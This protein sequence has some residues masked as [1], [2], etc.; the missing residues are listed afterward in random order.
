MT[1]HVTFG[2]SAGGSLRTALRTLGRGD[3]VLYLADDL[4]F[5]PIDVPNARHRMQW[6]D[7]ELGL[8]PL[9]EIE[10]HIAAFWRRVATEET[11]LVAW[12]SR[13]SVQEYCGFLELLRCAK[14][15]PISVVDVAD[16]EFPQPEMAM[17]FS[18]IGDK[19]ILQLGLLDRAMRVSDDDRARYLIEWQRLR[20]ENADL[21]ILTPSG[22]SSEPITYFDDM[23]VSLVT[24]D[25]QRCARVIGNALHVTSDG[26][27]RQCSSDVFLFE[28]LIRLIDDHVIDGRA[29]EE[30]WSLRESWVRRHR[31]E[32]AT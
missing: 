9:P 5:G 13:K 20:D 26:P 2:A 29:D 8:E 15:A 24:D 25:W 30:F 22:L 32:S 21:R 10:E 28:R 14:K 3:E 7:D 11:E 1:V 19:W 16:V 4:S 31:A 12:M 6:K 27:F 17:A 18:W 23:L